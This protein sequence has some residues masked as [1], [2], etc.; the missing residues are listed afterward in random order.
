[1]SAPIVLFLSL[2]ALAFAA[3]GT[4]ASPAQAGEADRRQGL[5]ADRPVPRALPQRAGE[6]CLR[7]TRHLVPVILLDGPG[8]QAVLPAALTLP[9]AHGPEAAWPAAPCAI[10]P[11]HRSHFYRAQAP[12]SPIG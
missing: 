12:P 9:A 11:S 7:E 5:S 3:I 1:M 4:G 6:V 10:V 8:G 2:L